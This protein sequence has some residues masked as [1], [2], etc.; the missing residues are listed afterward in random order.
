MPTVPLVEQLE[1]DNAVN[2]CIA[3]LSANFSESH[4]N[5]AGAGSNDGCKSDQTTPTAND[6]SS[7]V[8]VIE[9]NGLKST[10]V[11]TP[12]TASTKP[13]KYVIKCPEF[14]S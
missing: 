7:F 13:P 11:E 10:E 12:T 9:V 5:V 3:E 1:S 4:T 6:A 14:E 2:K 8:T